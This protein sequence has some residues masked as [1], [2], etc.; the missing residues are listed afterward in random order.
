[1]AYICFVDKSWGE[2]HS[3]VDGMLLGALLD[4]YPGTRTLFYRSS[5]RSERQI[6]CSPFRRRGVGR[7]L[8]P[9]WCVFVAL[10]QPAVRS[11]RS[12]VFIRNEFLTLF[13]LC[14]CK[15]TVWKNLRVIFQS[16]FPHEIYSGSLLSRPIAR[17]ILRFCAPIIDEIYVVSEQAR[18]RIRSYGVP[19]TTPIKTIPLC[20]D[21]E[22]V[23]QPR[24]LRS[25][26]R[27]MVY[28]GT[29]SSG[30]RLDVVIEA[31]LNVLKSVG[32]K[33]SITFIGGDKE[34]FVRQYPN[35]EDAL[36]I[37]E[38]SGV[39][40]FGGRVPR[41]EIPCALL[42]YDVGIN[43]VPV[44][45]GYLESSSTKLG[46]YLSRGLAVISTGGIPY[47]DYIHSLGEIGWL[48]NGDTPNAI[49]ESIMSALCASHGDIS[50]R[51]VAGREV[52]NRF[53]NYERYVGLF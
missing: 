38:A 2:G 31:C 12:S 40:N 28:V 34:E 16:S 1:M 11:G 10:A 7:L 39:L 52:A 32:P 53:L 3:F 44:T 50:E 37:L 25:T 51:S 6:N 36:N 15:V 30:R 14:L 49:G 26:F 8:H 43:Y 48:S 47:H 19:S 9:L 22:V 35:S 18:E 21:F 41:A 24:Q 42:E 17:V 4:R 27:R 33:W 23:S 20:T 45:E 29:F 5:L 13:L 46:E